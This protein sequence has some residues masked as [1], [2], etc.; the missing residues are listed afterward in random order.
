M[1]LRYMIS[2]FFFYAMYAVIVPY[3]QI[4]LYGK[5]LSPS[6][7]GLVIGVWEIAGIAGPLLLGALVD[8]SGRFR[9][10]L[11]GCSLVGSLLMLV[12]VPIDSIFAVTALTAL[13]GFA[14]KPLLSIN[15]SMISYALADPEHDYG[16]VRVAGSIGFGAVML[17]F[18]ITGIFNS[19]SPIMIARG[20]AILGIF[21]LLT[22]S[23]IPPAFHAR[24][25]RKTS[26]LNSAGK[27]EKAQMPSL[28][29]VL[30]AA[31]FLGRMG[32][33]SYYSFF[34][35]FLQEEL[36]VENVGIFW[37]IA[38]AAEIIPIMFAGKIIRITGRYRALLMGL[39]AMILRMLIYSFSQSLV[40]IG[41]AQLLHSLTFGLTH[42]A[43]ISYINE[44]VPQSKKTL[45]MSIYLSIAWG[46]GA[47]LGS[48][49]G[50][51]LVEVY[52][53]SRMFLLMTILPL[54]G[55]LLI[56]MYDILAVKKRWERLG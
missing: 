11:L 38:V 15:D 34:S 14:F 18:E 8:R 51:L 46:L 5:G 9:S 10:V 19:P 23:I 35:L 12:M 56:I 45:A 30:A 27:G 21:Y 49:V 33:T 17:F 26:V 53:F 39:A 37:M 52:G 25:S 43:C 50:G 31:V 29:Y 13:F 28:F 20:A 36:K 7:T 24:T 48:P 1:K 4:F 22:I 47:F 6:E 32:F 40:I 3:F 2:L 41:A 16:H 54:A 42:V 55:M 44:K